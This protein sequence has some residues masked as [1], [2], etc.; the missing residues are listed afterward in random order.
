MFPNAF[1]EH[2]VLGSL[3]GELREQRKQFREREECGW[4]LTSGALKQSS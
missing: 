4:R 2:F 3:L 1:L